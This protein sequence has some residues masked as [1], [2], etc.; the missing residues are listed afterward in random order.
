[1]D[2]TSETVTPATGL[3]VVAFLTL[4]LI[5]PVCAEAGAGVTSTTAAM[6]ASPAIMAA[7][8]WRSVGGM[9]SPLCGT[10]SATP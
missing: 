1:M 7:R 3:P 4:T 5:V 6:I 8:D 9:S 2:A 10:E